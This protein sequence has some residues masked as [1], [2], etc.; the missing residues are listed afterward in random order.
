VKTRD[1]RIL[2]LDED[3]GPAGGGCRYRVVDQE[4][5]GVDRYFRLPVETEARFQAGRL[6]RILPMAH[7]ERG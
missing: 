6:D 2:A 1:R 5:C 7:I 4:A 3:R